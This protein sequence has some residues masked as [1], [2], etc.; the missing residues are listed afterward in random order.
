MEIEAH[1]YLSIYDVSGRLV[2]TLVDRSLDEGTHDI[3]WNGRGA[4][5]VQAASGIYFYKLRTD[6][7]V[8]TR[9]MVLLR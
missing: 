9:K 5:G 6:G 2:S 3:D 7:E 4:N 1:G 8:L